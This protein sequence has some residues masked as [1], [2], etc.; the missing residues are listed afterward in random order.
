[1]SLTKQFC[2]LAQVFF[3]LFFPH[4]PDAECDMQKSNECA[5][6]C[7]AD[8]RRGQRQQVCRGAETMQSKCLGS[9]SHKDEST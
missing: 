4:S 6:Y 2:D 3:V 7:S 9:V 5:D 1:M 8:G